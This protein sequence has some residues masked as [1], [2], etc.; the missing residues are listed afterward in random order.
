[1]AL[2]SDA[3]AIARSLLNDDLGMKWSDAILIPKAQIAHR[4]LQVELEL[5]SIPVVKSQTAIISVPAGATDLG[6]TQ[7]A[8][9]VEPISIK[10]RDAGGTAEDLVSMTEVSFIPQ[11]SRSVSLIYWAWIGERITFLGATTNREVM[12]R[13]T[14]SLTVPR[15]ATDVLGFVGSELFLGPQIAYLATGEDRFSLQAA[16]ALDRLI[17]VNVKG[18]QGIMHRRRPYRSASRSRMGGI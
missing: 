7:P 16:R 18:M 9:L 11:A 6:L 5:N 3:L 2:L 10:E 15:T 4:E 12:L 14:K 8:D 1:M 13:Y 17:R